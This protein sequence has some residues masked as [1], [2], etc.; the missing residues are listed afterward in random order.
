MRVSYAIL[1][2]FLPELSLSPEEVIEILR[3]QGFVVEE[4][5]SARDLFLLPLWVGT[6]E[7]A[8]REGAFVLCTVKV[9]ERLFRVAVSPWGVPQVG[10]KI[11]LSIQNGVP[12]FFPVQG[13]RGREVYHDFLVALPPFFEEGD[14]V[15][16][17]LVGD[18]VVMDVEITANRGDCL[19]V[20]GLARELSAHCGI[21]L[22]VPEVRYT[23]K[24]GDHRFRLEN[25][26]LHL[27]PYYTGRYISSVTVK[28]SSFWI[29]KELLLMGMRPINNVVDITNLVMLEL[30]QP[31]HAFDASCIKDRTVLVREAQEGEKIVTLD[32]E[33]RTLR[34]GM[35]LIADISSPI[36]VAGIMGGAETEVTPRTRDVFLEA[37]IFDRVSIR[38]TAK[39]LGVRTEASS[40][41]ERGVDPLGVLF[42]ASRA[43]TLLEREGQAEVVGDWLTSGRPPVKE[44]EV[45]LYPSFISQRLSCDV[46]QE[47]SVHILRNLGFGVQEE[48]GVLRIYVPSWRHD[49]SSAID[50]VEE[51]GRVYGY[52]KIVASLPSFAFDP[53][54]IPENERLERRIREH[55][56]HRGLHEAVTLSFAGEKMLEALGISREGC[57]PVENPLSKEQAVLR[58]SLCVSLLEVAHTNIRKERRGFGFFEIGRVFLRGGNG[59]PFLE[60]RRMGVVLLG[61]SEPVLWQEN[62]VGFFTLKGILEEI[63]ELCGLGFRLTRGG[64]PSFLEEDASFLV[65]PPSRKTQPLGW[66][67]RVAQKVL[68]KLDIGEELYCLE[69]DL[70]LLTEEAQTPLCFEFSLPSF[71][72]VTRDISVV[73]DLLTPWDEVASLV[74][75][76]VKQRNMSLEHFRLF[77]VFSG[78]PLPPSKKGFAFRLVFRDPARTLDEREVEEWVQAIK[79]R[80]KETGRVMLREELVLPHD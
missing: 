71:P 21:P 74:L 16:E 50:I 36:A 13:E 7:E 49:V 75:E 33:E 65:Y 32:R 31:L 28:S 80:L 53:G 62:R 47:V 15:Y 9:R 6:L 66:G 37:A 38:R 22:V 25:R 18:D 46:P 60:R 56:V 20:L 27:C 67:G 5:F 24:S 12:L 17:A 69:I 64:T 63:G 44:R 1:K 55:L 2:R 52:D 40:R 29:M 54:N 19:S 76:E 10:S 23:E 51:V 72:S 79:G 73:V 68:Q 34:P 61:S 57:V 77:D 41:F 48:G 35:L 58:P 4:S 45:T 70:D 59:V 14:E 78:S 43:L 8:R 26:A 3:N 11:L 30:G 42:S 39:A